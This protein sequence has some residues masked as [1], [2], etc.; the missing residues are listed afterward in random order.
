[1]A[2]LRLNR[3]IQFNVFMIARLNQEAFVDP[4]G[5]EREQSRS[6]SVNAS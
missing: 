5:L 2:V 1:M 6:S 4:G 3:K